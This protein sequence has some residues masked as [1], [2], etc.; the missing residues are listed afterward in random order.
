MGKTMK[1]VSA[2]Q[3]LALIELGPLEYLRAYRDGVIAH[4]QYV[5][6]EDCPAVPTHVRQ[7]WLE[8]WEAAEHEWQAIQ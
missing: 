4:T 6:K 5:P 3:G 2:V 1:E 7:A 8:G